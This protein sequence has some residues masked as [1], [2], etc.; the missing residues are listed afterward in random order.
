MLSASNSQNDVG[1]FRLTI[2][3]ALLRKKMNI[4]RVHVHQGALHASLITRGCD[5]MKLNASQSRTNRKLSGASKAK[6][7]GEERTREN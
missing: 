7:G 5:L 3:Y 4:V 6:H 2:Y 1:C